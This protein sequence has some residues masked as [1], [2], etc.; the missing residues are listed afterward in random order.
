VAPAE[1]VERIAGAGARVGKAH[2]FDHFV[3]LARGR[4][5]ASKEAVRRQLA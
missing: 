3:G 1:F 5:D 2:G 4:Q